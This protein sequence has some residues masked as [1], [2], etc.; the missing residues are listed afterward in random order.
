MTCK[1][2][3]PMV[4]NTYKVNL[5]GILEEEYRCGLCGFIVI[6]ESEERENNEA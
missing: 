1:C 4:E 5:S 3:V 6:E 2:P